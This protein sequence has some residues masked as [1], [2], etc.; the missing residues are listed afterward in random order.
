MPTRKEIQPDGT[1][2][3]IVEADDLVAAAFLEDETGGTELSQEE[4]Q[5]LVVEMKKASEEETANP[6]GG[7]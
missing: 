4:F 6:T 5:E 7:E 3:W 2:H 1:T